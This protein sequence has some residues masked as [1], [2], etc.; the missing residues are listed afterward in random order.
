MVVGTLLSFLIMS[1]YLTD[2]LKMCDMYI[3]TCNRNESV[4]KQIQI[5]LPTGVSRHTMMSRHTVCRQIL[6]YWL[7]I[8]VLLHKI[9]Q[10][11][12]FNYVR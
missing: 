4:N 3:C 1:L 9:P 12:I 8:T 2:S 7:F 11:V 10:I 5:Q 6:K